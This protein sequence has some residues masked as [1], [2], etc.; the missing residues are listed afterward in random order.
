MYYD[1]GELFTYLSPG[2][3]SGVVT[4]G[5][6]GVAQAPPFVKTLY[7]NDAFGSPLIPNN[8]LSNP[9]CDPTAGSGQA[10]NCTSRPAE[11]TGSPSTLTVPTKATLQ[12]VPCCLLLRYMTAR[13]S[14]HTPLTSPS[15]CNGSHAT[16]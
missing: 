9:F 1:R 16:T 13:P 2:Y 6:Y 12:T 5:P 4:G 3:A 15:M 11:P 10:F 7:P 14:C 8:S